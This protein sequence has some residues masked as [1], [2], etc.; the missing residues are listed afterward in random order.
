MKTK[1]IFRFSSIFLIIILFILS[2]TTLGSAGK[3]IRVLLS[4]DKGNYE[5]IENLINALEG[6]VHFKHKY[7]EGMAV[8]VP[9]E[10]LSILSSTAEIKQVLKD[11]TIKRPQPVQI[12]RPNYGYIPLYGEATYS[13]SESITG[14]ELKGFLGDGTEGYYP[15]TN[16]LTNT[17]DFI[18]NTGHLGE[19]IIVGIIDD[20]V[21]SAATAI[22]SRTI[23]AENFTGD[24]IPGDSPLNQSHGTW[25]ACC[26]GANSIFGFSNPAIQ[27]A[28]KLYAPNSVI[29]DYFAPGIDGIPMIGQAPAAQFY[30]LKV[31]PAS[32]GGAPRSVIAAA[33]ERAIEL[34]TKFNDGEPDGVNIQV[35]NM[36]LG[37]SSLFA[38]N[39]PFYAPLAEAANSAG[40]L[41]V[42]SSGNEG[43]AG[44]TIGTPGDAKNILTVGATSDA[45]HERIVAD[46]FFVGAGGGYLWRPVDNNQ[47]ADF[48]SRGPTADGRSDPEIVAPGTWRYCQNGNGS[49]INW[50]SGT[51]FSSP[52]IA[53]AAA[54]L[55]SAV[56]TSTPDQIRAALCRSANKNILDDNSEKQDRGF[57]FLDVSEAYQKLIS[58]VWNPIDFA[59]E[60]PLVSLNIFLGAQKTVILSP[61]YTDIA[62]DLLPGERKEYYYNI[63]KFTERVTVT[64]SSVTP[65]LPPEEQN[66]LFGDDLI[67]AIHSAKTSS[68]DDYRALTPAFVGAGGATFVLEGS[69]LD[70]GAARIVLMGDWTNAGA[71]SASVNIASDYQIPGCQTKTGKVAEGESKTYT[72][73]IPAGTSEFNLRLEWN[74]GWDRYPTDDLDMAVYDPDNNLILLDND[75]DDDNDGISLDAPERLNLVS[76]AAGTY[77]VSVEGFTVW[78]NKEKFKL[79]AD[80]VGGTPFNLAKQTSAEALPTEFSLSQNYPNPFNPSSV[81]NYDLPHDAFVTLNVYDIQGRLVRTLIN[82]NNDAGYHSVIFNGKNDTGNKLASGMYIYRIT[83]PEFTQVKKMLLL[84]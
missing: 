26:V 57:G 63:S 10:N 27:N 65:E 60:L 14:D 78:E 21:S 73:D 2:N 6:T 42:V 52:T 84:K 31:F 39:D 51:S 36:S 79:Y 18:I 16:D 69:D 30:S 75:G 7:C 67:V 81:I 15:F 9:E 12:S 50:V 56:P 47:V 28:V 25:V 68:V 44:M 4:V 58:S 83:T 34:K 62:Q 5:K 40:I 43:P 66:Q 64:V 35:V 38:G 1:T 55:L 53:G 61:N 41:M 3:K 45:T 19:N 29:P 32:G 74:D 11:L 71:I 13:N 33:L 77:T 54:L 20:G 48:S 72:F 70:Q 59:W 8:S 49:S 76:P 22:A 23:G 24:G 17:N 82:E 46:L 37:G 80:I